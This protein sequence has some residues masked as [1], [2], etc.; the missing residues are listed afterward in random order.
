MRR[1]WALYA[2]LFVSS[3]LISGV[4]SYLYERETRKRLVWLVKAEVAASLP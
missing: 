2:M 4:I 3:T 1:D